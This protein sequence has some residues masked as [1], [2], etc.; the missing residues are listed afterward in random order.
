M[1][2]KRQSKIRIRLLRALMLMTLLTL[3]METIHSAIIDIHMMRH[4]MLRDLQVLAEVVGRN[5]VSA[6]VFDNPETAQRHLATLDREYQIRRALLYDAE[7]HEFARWHR[8]PP[9]MLDSGFFSSGAAGLRWILDDRV[10]ASHIIDFDGRS[11]GR[12]VIEARLDELHQK[13]RQYLLFDGV[14]AVLTLAVAFVIAERLQERISSPIL[15]LARQSRKI[16]DQKA[17]SDRIADPMAGE[18]LTTLVDGFNAVLGAIEQRESELAHHVKALDRANSQLRRLATDMALVEESERAR[19]AGELHDS[20]MQKLALAQMQIDAAR[21]G[22]DEESEEQLASG[23]QLLCEGISEI[24]TLQFDLS[25]P[26]LHQ[27]GLSAALEWLATST[28]SRWGIAMTCMLEPELPELGHDLS[29][30]LFQ[31]A[32]ELVYNLIKHARASHGAIRLAAGADGL[33]MVVED[34]GVGVNPK[35]VLDPGNPETGF[36]L[37][38][39]RERIALIGGTLSVEPLEPGTRIIIRLPVDALRAVPGGRWRGTRQNP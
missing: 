8:Q 34:D 29:V 2:R 38:N 37:F 3:S 22:N 6:L 14:L 32:R 30:I 31:V 39:V 17:F 15:A 10:T 35:V 18:E 28:T 13:L 27:K 16:S 5:C 25:P 26:I 21:R 4:Q 24:R 36:G 1:M 12:I 33:K 7:G 9:A 23:V 20:P 19:L 11:V